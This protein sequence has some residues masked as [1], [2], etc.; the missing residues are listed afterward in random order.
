[1][2]PVLTQNTDQRINLMYTRGNLENMLSLT[3]RPCPSQDLNPGPACC[4][5]TLMKR[6]SVDIATCFILFF[7]V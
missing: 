2:T 5:A 1:M 4:E 7:K 6:N 3:E